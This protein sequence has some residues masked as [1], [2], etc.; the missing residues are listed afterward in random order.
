MNCLPGK[1]INTLHFP[2]HVEVAMGIFIYIF[3]FNMAN[4]TLCRC[5]S[6]MGHFNIRE[7]QYLLVDQDSTLLTTRY[8]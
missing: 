2:P 7:N 6:K 3:G 4:N 5:Y 8:R 1:L